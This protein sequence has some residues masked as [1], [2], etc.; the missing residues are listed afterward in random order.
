MGRLR[1]EGFVAGELMWLSRQSSFSKFPGGSHLMTDIELLLLQGCCCYTALSNPIHSRV[2]SAAFLCRFNRQKSQKWLFGGKRVQ[3]GVPVHTFEG[4]WMWVVR[5]SPSSRPS[6][7]FLPTFWQEA[8][9]EGSQRRCGS[10][11][12]AV[13]SPVGTQQEAIPAV[14][15]GW[16]TSAQPSHFRVSYLW[17]SVIGLD[18]EPFH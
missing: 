3:R 7:A 15:V 13:K 18:I 10:G 17:L 11:D 14:R 2:R 16:N 1:L 4:L 5:C 8:A 12:L 6:P 9:A